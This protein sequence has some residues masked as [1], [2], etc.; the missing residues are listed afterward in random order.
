MFSWEMN[1]IGSTDPRDGIHV[2]KTMFTMPCSPT[3]TRNGKH[4]TYKIADDQ[5]IV[6]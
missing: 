1:G 2:G 3:M 5:G 6:Y 4:T